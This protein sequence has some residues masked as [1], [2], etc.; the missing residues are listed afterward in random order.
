M[1]KSCGDSM[2]SAIV[3]SVPQYHHWGQFASLSRA[4]KGETDASRSSSFSNAVKDLIET[5]SS[6]VSCAGLVS[7]DRLHGSCSPVY[8]PRAPR[9][10]DR[11]AWEQA[12]G[13]SYRRIAVGANHFLA[14]HR[15]YFHLWEA[16]NFA[17]P[18]CCVVAISI[19]W[20]KGEEAGLPRLGEGNAHHLSNLC[21]H[22]CKQ[23]SRIRF[24]RQGKIYRG[25]D[26]TRDNSS[27]CT[28]MRRRS[29]S[30]SGL[31]VE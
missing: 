16:L 21:N 25:S 4:P 14:T 11:Q 20:W 18:R 26:L 13:T 3:S 6:S 12:A 29:P 2:E 10:L 5:H 17:R 19:S 7:F 23:G 30:M 1:P 24:A 31:R 28:V 27:I 9:S 22:G 8:S 15:D